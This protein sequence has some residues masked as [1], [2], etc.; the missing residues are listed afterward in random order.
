MTSERCIHVSSR[1][2]MSNF[3][4][5]EVMTAGYNKSIIVPVLLPINF[6]T[7]RTT[8]DFGIGLF[9]SMQCGTHVSIVLTFF[10]NNVQSLRAAIGSKGLDLI[11][12]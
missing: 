7:H 3:V 9:L 11:N 5:R 8:N 2:K 4:L 10:C 6:G 12:S 1:F